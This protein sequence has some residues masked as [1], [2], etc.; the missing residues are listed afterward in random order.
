MTAILSWHKPVL[1]ELAARR[2]SERLP[3]AMLL[4][5]GS[6][7]EAMAF[8]NALPYFILCDTHDACGRC[9]ACRLLEQGAHSDYSL[10]QPEGS[11]KVIKIDQIRSLL[12]FG[13]KTANYPSGK[14]L[15]LAP[16][17]ALNRN[18][19]NAL[20]KFLEEPPDNTYLFLVASRASQL[21]A[22]VMSRCQKCVVARPDSQESLEFLRDRGLSDL[23][24]QMLLRL[25]NDEPLLALEI[26]ESDTADVLM[27]AVEAVEGVLSGDVGPRVVGQSTQGLDGNLLL[28]VLIAN[29]HQSAVVAANENKLNTRL[30]RWHKALLELHGT[31][32]RSPNINIPLALEQL[33]VNIG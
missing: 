16:A 18:A 8:A 17:S 6:D 29:A 21:P 20:L 4:A 30:L 1:E 15:V 2:Q 24:A 22:T 3:H 10:C 23:R 13:C 27:R 12:N 5:F 28:M 19:A 33:C 14:V 26:E 32:L 9:R 11:S 7:P 31:Y 25:A